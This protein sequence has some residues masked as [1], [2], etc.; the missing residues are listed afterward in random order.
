MFTL[1]GCPDFPEELSKLSLSEQPSSLYCEKKADLWRHINETELEEAVCDSGYCSAYH[2]QLQL[3]QMLPA[4]APSCLPVITQAGV[5][6]FL[7]HDP[8]HYG[9]SQNDVAGSDYSIVVNGGTGGR[10]SWQYI[11]PGPVNAASDTV[12][13]P[14]DITHNT[15]THMS[16]GVP[17]SADRD[18]SRR[19]S[20]SCGQLNTAAVTSRIDNTTQA[21]S[22]FLL[23]AGLCAAQP[24]CYC[25]YSVV[26]EWVFCPAGATRYPDKREI[27]PGERTIGLQPPCQI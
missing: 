9:F 25:F 26:Q 10:C 11:H 24:C 19:L 15:G 22:N 21:V 2:D 7:P 20:L 8:L 18:M 1:L 12:L 6:M 27:W 3:Q 13:L 17:H 16:A 4:V 5:L 14:P 23:P